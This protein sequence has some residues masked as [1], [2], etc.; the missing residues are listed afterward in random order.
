[1]IKLSQIIARKIGDSLK[2]DDEKVAVMSYGLFGMLQV[3]VI[4]AASVIMGLIFGFFWEAMILFFSVGFLRRLIGGAHSQGLMSCMIISIL[5]IAILSLLARYVLP[6]FGF[7]FAAAFSAFVYLSASCLIYKLAPV[8][9]PNKP[10]RAPEKIKRLRKSSFAV[11][12]SFILLTVAA[13]ILQYKGIETAPYIFALDLSV[14]WQSCMLTKLS[15][16][17]LSRFDRILKAVNHNF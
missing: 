8:D 6:A 3:A 10:V 11:M 5:S 17:L 15:H 13:L 16:K 1:M 12:L 4:F 9:S 14:L 2:L 7:V